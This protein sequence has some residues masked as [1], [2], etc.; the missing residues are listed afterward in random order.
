MPK[1]KYNYT[2][3]KAEFLNSDFTEVKS[4]ITHK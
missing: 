1:Q 3:L 4:F 2:K